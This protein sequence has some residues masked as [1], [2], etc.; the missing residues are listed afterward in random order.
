MVLKKTYRFVNKLPRVNSDATEDY[1]G[2]TLKSEI[3]NTL[4]IKAGFLHNL[5][6]DKSVE[7]MTVFSFSMPII[8][9]RSSFGLAQDV[10]TETFSKEDHKALF[11][12]VEENGPELL[13]VDDFSSF[14]QQELSRWISYYA[15]I[16]SRIAPFYEL[17]S[18]VDGW[19]VYKRM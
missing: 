16:R 1:S 13:L 9:G 3:A 12:Q 18:S 6:T 2:L 14:N 19:H 5:P 7:Y 11:K 15:R 17:E 4:K 10:F 8:S